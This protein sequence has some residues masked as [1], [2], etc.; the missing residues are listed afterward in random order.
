[1][2]YYLQTG[3]QIRRLDELEFEIIKQTQPLRLNESLSYKSNTK[4]YSFNNSTILETEYDCDRLF[5][6]R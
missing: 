6:I 4:V 2:H 1:M 5:K 3:E